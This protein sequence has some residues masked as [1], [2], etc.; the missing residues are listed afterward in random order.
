M[1]TLIEG[2]PEFVAT[3]KELYKQ[4][5]NEWQITPH[6]EKNQKALAEEFK[7]WRAVPEPANMGED[8]SYLYQVARYTWNKQEDAC[9]TAGDG[10]DGYLELN[11]RGLKFFN[12]Y[13]RLYLIG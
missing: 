7:R 13:K 4:A 2:S 6:G 3:E 11:L 12:H 10:A 5:D 1:S 9:K 8:Q